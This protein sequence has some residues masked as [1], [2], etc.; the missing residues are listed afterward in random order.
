MLLCTALII[1]GEAN[2]DSTLP[3][4]GTNQ[5]NQNQSHQRFVAIDANKNRSA[6]GATDSSSLNDIYCV[7]DRHTK[8]YWEV[9]TNDG[10]LQDVNQTYSWYQPGMNINGGFPGYRDRGQCQLAL[11]D[12]LAYIAAVNN[13]KPCGLPTWRLPT[14]KELRS[15]VDYSIPY[16]GPSINKKFFPNTKNQFY[17]SSTPNANDSLAAWGI[18]FSFGYDYAYFKSDHGYIR[19]VSGPN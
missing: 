13:L 1:T 3:K 6:N 8:L 10:G 9:K 2:S 5:N 4:D 16:P 14:R 15:L 12:T 11:C 19:L 7:F 18:G 17:W